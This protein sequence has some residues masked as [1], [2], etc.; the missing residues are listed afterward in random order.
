MSITLTTPASLNTILGGNTLV[1]YDHVVLSPLNFNPVENTVSSTVRITA[2]GD[3]EM[4]VVIGSL[5][6]NVGQGKLTFQV[7]Q[8]D[9]VRKMQLSAPQITAIQTI[10]SN[11]QDALESG[12]ISVGVIAGVQATGT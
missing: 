9:M 10:M 8:L 5:S 7:P 12:L 1:D 3:P 6:I 11:A 4:D 2:S